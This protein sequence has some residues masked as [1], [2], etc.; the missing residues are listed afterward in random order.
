MAGFATNLNNIAA[1]VGRSNVWIYDAEAT[2]AATKDPNYFDDAVDYG[3]RN[4]DIMTVVCTDATYQCKIAV[5]AGVVTLS[6]LD[7]F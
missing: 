7:A 2:A 4:Q 3:M 6:A 5:A 1:S